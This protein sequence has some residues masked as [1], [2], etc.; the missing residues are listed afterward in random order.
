MSKP[1][2]LEDFEVHCLQTL[3][4]NAHDNLSCGANQEQTLKDNKEA[5]KRCVATP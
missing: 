3:D 2:C 4:R 5:F 1:V